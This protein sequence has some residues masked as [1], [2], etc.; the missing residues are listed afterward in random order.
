ME[1]K[2]TKDKIGACARAAHLWRVAPGERFLPGDVHEITDHVIGDAGVD[3]EAEGFNPDE[4]RLIVRGILVDMGGYCVND[5]GQPIPF[6]EEER[7]Y[8]LEQGIIFPVTEEDI[9][10]VETYMRET[11]EPVRELP[12]ELRDPTRLFPRLEEIDREER[13]RERD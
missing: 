11:N 8:L 9:R 10:I 6:T 7:R 1:V 3:Y 13:E 4:V 5:D 2:L 12:E